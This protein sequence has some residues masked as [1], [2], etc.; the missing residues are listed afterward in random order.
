[1]VSAKRRK[2]RR[3]NWP[4]RLTLLG[5]LLTLV[6]YIGIR[7]LIQR[8]HGYDWNLALVSSLLDGTIATWFLAVGASIGSFLNVV[9]YR[10]P[11]GRN[12]GGHS[13][14]PFCQVRI[15]SADNVPFL[16]WIK[17]RGRC[18]SCRLPISIQYPIVEL[19]VGI[20]FLVVYLTEF[21][22]SG[23]NLPVQ[24]PDAIRRVLRAG[25]TPE[26]VQ[27]LVAYLFLLSGLI[28]AALI[29]V[30][31][32]VVPMSLYLW[33]LA[34]LV[35]VSL[36]TPS[37]VI[38]RWREAE[39]A[40]FLE[41]RMDAFTTLLCG[42]VAG[43]AMARVVAPLVYRGF[44]RSLMSL[45][46][47]SSGARQFMGAMGAAGAILGWQ[48]V[49][50]F[51]WMLVLAALLVVGWCRRWFPQVWLRDFTIWVWLGLLL[52]RATWSVWQSIRFPDSVPPVLLYVAGALLLAPL[53]A[54]WVQCTPPPEQ[55]S[56]TEQENE[57]DDED[58][59]EEEEAQAQDATSDTS[60]SQADESEAAD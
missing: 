54:I 42:L 3:A 31:Q 59:W 53:C 52:F 33:S 18:R 41:S 16:A 44:D 30:R 23:G 49:V 6:A 7:V 36:V 10:L 19:A 37:V 43:V 26:F 29:A 12:V 55:I 8:S 15:H 57:D 25:V 11:I 56:A 2:R 35:V 21:R 60:D 38:V 20:V 47:S 32:R 13:A 28:A 27:R 5:L 40:G 58:G 9:A 50:P 24:G 39:A 51:A 1:M 48:A 45:D 14:C 4:Y 46:A 34:P 17:L 22:T